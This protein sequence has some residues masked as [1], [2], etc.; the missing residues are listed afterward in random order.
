MKSNSE[1]QKKQKDS[2]LIQSIQRAGGILNLFTSENQPLGITDFSERLGL[3]KTTI[4][5]IVNTLA[6]MEYLEKDPSSARYRLGPRLFQLG[7]SYAT[8]LDMINTARVWMER[9]CFQF[10]E[11]VNVGMLVGSRVLVLFRVEPDNRFTP[12]PQTGSIIP[13]HT[14]CIGKILFAFMPPD[15]S[16]ILLENYHFDRLTDNTI[17]SKDAF[18][19]EL[20]AVRE[21]G[22]SFD[23]EENFIGLAGIGGPIF[24]H[25]G[26]VNA[27]FT[28]TGNAEHI[29]SIRE[30][31]IKEVT[32]TSRQV[33]SQFGYRHNS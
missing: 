25:T 11:P 3:P 6:S 5:G 22:I 30:E 9:L 20:A 1:M 13:A 16:D 2:R 21:T 28:V 23:N 31:I 33:S 26:Q 15:R 4:Q 8:N 24:N 7:L 17:T 18:L 27:A 14:T 10:R 19:N 32:Y 12:F 29:N